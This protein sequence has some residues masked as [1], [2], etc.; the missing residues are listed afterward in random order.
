MVIRCV[1]ALS[2]IFSD[3]RDAFP[4]S[5]SNSLIDSLFRWLERY[6]LS[7]NLSLPT[8]K[9]ITKHSV[10]AT[11]NNGY[12]SVSIEDIARLAGETCVYRGASQGIKAPLAA[13]QRASTTVSSRLLKLLTRK[14]R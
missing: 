8:T 2:K 9:T 13:A 4:D 6:L 5:L 3:R 10:V 14:R 1:A 7:Y 12:P 11:M